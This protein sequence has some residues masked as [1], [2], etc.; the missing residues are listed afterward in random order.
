[1]FSKLAVV[2]VAAFAIFV[3]AAP[4]N[5]VGNGG[6]TSNI[7]GVPGSLGD[8][9]NLPAVGSVGNLP[10]VGSAGN[11][12]AVG[13]VGNLPAVGSVGNL[14]GTASNLPAV[15]SVGSLPGTDGNLPVVNGVWADEPDNATSSTPGS[16]STNS[17]TG[18][19]HWYPTIWNFIVLWQYNGNHPYH[20]RSP[21]SD[22]ARQSPTLVPFRREYQPSQLTSSTKSR[23]ELR[24]L[25]QLDA[26][27][28]LQSAQ[29]EMHDLQS[30]YSSLGAGS[31]SSD[32]RRPRI[33]YHT[34]TDPST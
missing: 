13:S 25:R 12:P 4:V 5:S 23:D 26:H 29:L 14:P 17:I 11:L 19:R 6:L 3:A 31:S 22:L 27:Q 34:Q 28:G 8:A 18:W 1:M 33:G 2:A 21:S 30:I 32:V 16:S 9:G 7:G 24:P 20:I 10:A 15:G